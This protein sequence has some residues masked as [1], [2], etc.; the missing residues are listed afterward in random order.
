LSVRPSGSS[1]GRIRLGAADPLWFNWYVALPGSAVE[2]KT[3]VEAAAQADALGL[4]TIVGSEVQTVAPEIPKKLD[5]KLQKGERDAVLARLKDLNVQ[6]RGYSVGNLPLGDAAKVLPF[7]KAMGAMTA[8]V[9]N[10]FSGS[11]EDLERLANESAVNIPLGVAPA[12]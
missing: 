4:G 3:F 12:G 2:G 11:L 5:Y 8:I 9:S 7:A 1:L 10:P 6:M